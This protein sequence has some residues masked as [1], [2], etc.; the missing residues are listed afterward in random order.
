[1]NCGPLFDYG[2]TGGTWSYTGDGYDA[3]TL[4]P[5]EGD[6]QLE[7]AGSIP[8]GVLG[9]RCYGRTTLTEGQ[10]A[11]VALSWGGTA[12]FRPTWTRRCS[13][14]NSHRRFLA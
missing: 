4:T 9:A 6:L 1:M 8:L 7:L 10:S 11:F 13:A 14:L 2:R 5:A 3:M 12:M